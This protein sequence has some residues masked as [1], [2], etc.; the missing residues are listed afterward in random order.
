MTCIYLVDIHLDNTSKGLP[1][2]LCDRL[3]ILVFKNII[4]NCLK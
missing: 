2:R 4:I 1:L 3:L